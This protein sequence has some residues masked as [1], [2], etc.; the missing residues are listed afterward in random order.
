MKTRLPVAIMRFSA[1]LL[2]IFLY[3]G[4]AQQ[5]KVTITEYVQLITRAGDFTAADKA[6]N[7]YKAA[8]GI[9]PEYLDAL[10]R[11]GR[12]RL[13]GHNLAAAD[14][15]ATEVRGLCLA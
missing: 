6:L 4:L 14:Q 8:L 2:A 5:Q 13:A 10:S 12:A 7:Q 15:N 9:T 11:V 3:P 1:L